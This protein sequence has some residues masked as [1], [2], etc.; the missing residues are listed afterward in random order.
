MPAGIGPEFAAD[1]RILDHEAHRF[2][3]FLRFDEAPKLGGRQNPSLY[4]LVAELTDQTFEAL[5]A[6]GVPATT[7]ERAKLEAGWP[8]IDAVVETGLAKSKSDA[9]RL[10]SQGGIYLNNNQISD[11]NTKLNPSSLATSSALV[12]RSG[13]KTY[14]LVRVG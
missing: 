7:I 14:R 11:V 5:A 6:Q 2:R 1:S 13:K 3:N 9:R 4:E 8:L 10:I 12:L